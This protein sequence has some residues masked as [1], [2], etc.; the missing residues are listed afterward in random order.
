MIEQKL[1]SDNIRKRKEKRD[2][3]R[4]EAKLMDDA[5]R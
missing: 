5:R 3:K 2:M 1:K 4:F